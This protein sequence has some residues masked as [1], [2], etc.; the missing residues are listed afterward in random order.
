[1]VE[2][3]G[4]ATAAQQV[5]NLSAYKLREAAVDRVHGPP[6]DCLVCFRPPRPPLLRV[7]LRGASH[8]AQ[9]VPA[10]TEMAK[11]HDW[12]LKMYSRPGC[13]IYPSVETHNPATWH[14]KETCAK[15]LK[16]SYAEASNNP[17]DVLFVQATHHSSGEVAFDPNSK[18]YGAT[19][20][21]LAASGTHIIALRETPRFMH[22]NGRG[23]DTPFSPFDRLRNGGNLGRCSSVPHSFVRPAFREAV[24]LQPNVTFLDMGDNLCPWDV[25]KGEGH[26]TDTAAWE[27]RR[28]PPV[29]GGRAVYRDYQHVSVGYARSLAGVLERK[30]RELGPSQHAASV[31]VGQLQALQ[32][33]IGI[34][35][36]RIC[37]VRLRVHVSAPGH[38]RPHFSMISSGRYRGC[39]MRSWESHRCGPASIESALS[40]R[41]PGVVQL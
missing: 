16:Q 5:R 3:A 7:Q 32:G 19:R 1:M 13:D 8:A 12:E 10:L 30:L 34:A 37:L 23:E 14:S 33:T 21:L 15:W 26:E 39:W 25:S 28:C 22:N 9:W 4:A 24:A 29:V 38:R 40:T 41:T 27:E 36:P 11:R 17:P 20:G 6:N 31:E 35:L 2:R 18:L